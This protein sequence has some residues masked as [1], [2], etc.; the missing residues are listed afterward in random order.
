MKGTVSTFF[1]ALARV[2]FALTLVAAPW[3]FGSYPLDWQPLVFGGMLVSLAAW[4]LSVLTRPNAHPEGHTVLV[5][6]LLPPL[7]FV[8]LAAVQLVPMSQKEIVP[9]HA[10]LR[11]LVEP[12]SEADMPASP[13]PTSVYPAATRLESARILLALCTA[14]LAIQLYSDARRRLWLYVPIALNA[15]ALA[16]FGIWQKVNWEDWNQ[17][18]YGS[19]PLRFGGLPFGPFVNRNNAAG[20]LNLGICAAAGWALLSTAPRIGG[21]LR[22]VTE[23]R[24]AGATRAAGQSRSPF[25]GFG[26]IACLCIVASAAGVV[27]SLSRGGALGMLAAGIAAA[28]ILIQSQRSRLAVVGALVIIPAVIGASMY[29]GYAKELRTRLESLTSGEV[30]QESRLTHW[31]ETWG[32]VEDFP[33]LGG[34]LGAYRYIHRPYQTHEIPGTYANADNQFFEWL[35]ETG[36][37]G[38]SLIVA[39]LAMVAMDVRRLATSR[40]PW[41]QRDAALMGAMLLGSQ[42]VQSFTDF[43]II[44]PSNLLTAAAL[45]GVVIGT[46]AR[47]VPFESIAN[48]QGPLVFRTAPALLI[49]LVFLVGGGLAWWEVQLAANAFAARNRL[50]SL[51]EQDFLSDSDLDYAIAATTTAAEKRPD[52]AELQQTI[53]DLWL[54]RNRRNAAKFLA[55]ISTGRLPEAR[56]LWTAAPVERWVFTFRQI[57]EQG[58]EADRAEL[59]KRINSDRSLEH[60][61]DHYRQAVASCRWQPRSSE[62]E[63]VISLILEREP[64]LARVPLYR[65]ALVSP[66]DPPTLLAVAALSDLADSSELGTAC[67]RRSLELDP[68]MLGEAI[69]ISSVAERNIDWWNEALPE[70][71][72]LWLSAAERVAGT[73]VA[74]KVVTKSEQLLERQGLLPTSPGDQGRIALLKGN[75]EQALQ[76]FNEAL[77]QNPADPRWPVRIATL[78]ADKGEVAAAIKVL[79]EAETRIAGD[80]A[81]RGKLIDLRKRNERAAKSSGR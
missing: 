62:R 18:I 79:E 22:R 54:Y 58:R 55:E 38:M 17:M 26:L 60:G 49:G 36:L 34:G 67:L 81:I 80:S 3:P 66:A 24:L 56:E 63:A 43:G 70:D 68:G 9:G 7:L 41:E 8:L 64:Q 10:A 78:L 46:R 25:A 2:I 13:V 44:V 51:D 75:D 6:A 72:L 19:V 28:W 14:F 73:P 23:D 15:A 77:V 27:A 71:G 48:T 12:L 40:G 76:L 65:E 61:L 35:V 29:L 39:F 20:Y 30:M 50:S 52:D 21:G 1:A 45:G 33:W 57:D 4:W 37:V 53:G 32:A 31:R 5:D 16:A 42:V 11:N 74:D 69:T 47:S 59:L